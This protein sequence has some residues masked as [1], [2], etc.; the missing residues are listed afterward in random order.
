MAVEELAQAFSVLTMG[1]LSMPISRRTTWA[2]MHSWPVISPA[3]ALPTIATCRSFLSMPAASRAAVTASWLSSLRPRSAYLPK[4]VI[5][6]PTIATFLMC[7]SLRSVLTDLLPA[8]PV[9]RNPLAAAGAEAT[10]V[11]VRA[12]DVQLLFAR[13]LHRLQLISHQRLELHAFEHAVH[14]G[15]GRHS[16]EPHLPRRL[17]EV[18][19]GVLCDHPVGPR[20]RRHSDLLA[21]P[22]RAVQVAGRGHEVQPVD[23]LATLQP[24]HDQRPPALRGDL[25]GAAGAAEASLRPLVGAADERGVEV[26]E[27]VDL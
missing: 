12:D 13:R 7:V 9:D 16:D 6:A 3:A 19:G 14:R 2:R 18:E 15:P 5:P 26:A 1:I 10:R 25:V 4:R 8:L 21:R 22:G 20:V 11:D 17:V 27:A 24:G 23:E